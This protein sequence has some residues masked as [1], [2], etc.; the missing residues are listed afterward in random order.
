M[1]TS[2]TTLLVAGTPDERSTS[3]AMS[4][5]G[6]GNPLTCSAMRRQHFELLAA[7][8]AQ[9]DHRYPSSVSVDASLDQL[10]ADGNRDWLQLPTDQDA[11]DVHDGSSTFTQNNSDHLSI[12]HSSHHLS[13]ERDQPDLAHSTSKLP[14]SPP[15]T[16]QVNETSTRVAEPFTQ[17]PQHPIHL[18]QLPAPHPAY[19]SASAPPQTHSPLAQTS[20]RS[21]AAVELGSQ[22]QG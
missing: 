17:S 18:A 13:Q 9:D 20:A 7:P 16:Y 5:N 2:S 11:T 19:Q 15:T 22:T 8:I 6:E 4:A 1:A 10:T 12:N 21:P 14:S 3:E